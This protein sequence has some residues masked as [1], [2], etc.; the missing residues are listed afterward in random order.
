MTGAGSV[1][2]SRLPLQALMLAWLS[3]QK[4][5][6]KSQVETAVWPILVPNHGRDAPTWMFFEW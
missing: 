2:N 5:K 3:P 4:D 1:L 6:S